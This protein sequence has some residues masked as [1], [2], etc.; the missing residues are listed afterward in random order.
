MAVDFFA[1][2]AQ[3]T[4]AAGIAAGATTLTV[5]S[6][7]P[8]PAVTTAAA[9]QFRVIIDA[10]LFLVTN[11]TGTTWTV[12]PGTEGTAQAAH[13][14]A[15][16]VTAIL[17]AAALASKSGIPAG[18]TTNQVLKKNTSADGDAG[19]FTPTTVE[20]TNVPLAASGA[21]TPGALTTA[22][23]NDHIH[24]ASSSGGAGGIDAH[25]AIIPATTVTGN[26]FPV[27]SGGTNNNQGSNSR[28]QAFPCRV[29]ASGT[30]LLGLEV[31]AAVA[32]S[33]VRLAIFADNATGTPGTMLLDTG[34]LSAATTGQKFGAVSVTLVAGTRYWFLVGQEAGASAFNYRCASIFS[35]IPV[36]I[37]GNQLNPGNN[38]RIGAGPY[39][40]NP[41]II[42]TDCDLGCP[43]F[44]LKVP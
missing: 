6:S 14:N 1:N 42:I 38:Y 25:M 36:G 11:V 18:G 20:H 21:G 40:S 22:S 24:P 19:W 5:A 28:A 27:V 34:Q 35:Q 17:T 15:A 12:T 23:A 29:S 2:N 32:S 39:A 4:L 30:F 7:T 13:A 9:T 26:I 43:C 8:F 41:A 31:T 33:F 44:L 10:E 3:T 16:P 37:T